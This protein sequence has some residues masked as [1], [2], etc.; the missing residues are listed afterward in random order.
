MNAVVFAYHDVGVRCLKVLLARGVQVS[1]VVT[2]EDNAAENIWFGSVAGVCREHGITC[3]TPTDPKSPQLLAQVQAA[4]PDFIFSFYYRHMLPVEVLATARRGA[5]N[6]HGSLLPKYRGR[7]PIN[8]AVLH[9][10]TET[11]A[12]LHEMTVKPDAGSIVAQ[13]AVPILPDD[14]AHEVFG[15][16]V[17]AAEMTLWTALPA[18]LAGR[19]PQLPNDLSKGSYFSGRKPEDGRIDWRRTAREVH[20]LVRAV[21]PPY[22][23]AFEEIAGDKITV[24]RTRLVPPSAHPAL[25]RAHGMQDKFFEGGK[26]YARCGDGN[27]LQILG[28][29]INDQD[30]SLNNYLKYMAS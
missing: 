6:M 13:T 27:F 4:Q 28:I 12:T 29:Q 22:P 16:V 7:V 23:G 3:I 17:V 26:L 1:L 10:E 30:A 25:Q 20:N 2:H 11:G 19:T 8:W 5:Y 18:M 15:K 9:G 21:A 24:T 14:T